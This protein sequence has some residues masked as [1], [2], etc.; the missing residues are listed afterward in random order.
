MLDR[1][2]TYIGAIVVVSALRSARAASVAYPLSI[3]VCVYGVL[4]TLL[5]PRMHFSARA[6]SVVG[7]LMLPLVCFAHGPPRLELQHVLGGSALLACVLAAY[8]AL[9][10][11]PYVVSPT[12][13]VVLMLG[14]T[15]ALVPFATLRP[16]GDA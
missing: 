8:T 6:G 10:Y 3:Q 7:H 15:A 13:S 16:L 4:E 12:H 14:V 11:W 5:V 2:S 1:A 9:D